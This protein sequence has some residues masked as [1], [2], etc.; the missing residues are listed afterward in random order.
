MNISNNIDDNI[1]PKNIINYKD[2]I[3][4]KGFCLKKNI[5][6]RRILFIII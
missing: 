3:N 1:S 6:N 4:K 2:N 5:P